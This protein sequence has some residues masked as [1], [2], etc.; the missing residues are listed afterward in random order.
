MMTAD[1]SLPFFLYISFGI[2]YNDKKDEVY[3]D[4]KG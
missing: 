2:W 1:K 3:E 4:L